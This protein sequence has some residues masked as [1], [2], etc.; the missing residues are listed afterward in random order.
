M[1]CISPSAPATPATVALSSE[2]QPSVGTEDRTALQKHLDFFDQNKDGYVTVSESARGLSSLGIPSYKAWPGAFVVN[3]V[4]GTMTYGYPSTTIDT[5]RIARAKHE[6]DTGVYD[7]QGKFVQAK[8]DELFTTFDV[9]GDGALNGP[10]IEALLTRNR[11]GDFGAALA[12]LELPVLLK[13]AGEDKQVG[14]DTV[15]VLSRERLQEFYDGTLFY[16]IAAE[17]AG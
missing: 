2:S 17:N 15:R 9:D 13:V 12:R 1:P 14:D 7:T 3:S 5:S 10:E 11:K 4:I 8:F 6:G 16:D